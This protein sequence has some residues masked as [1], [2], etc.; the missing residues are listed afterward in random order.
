MH[1]DNRRP[2]IRVHTAGRD[3]VLTLDPQ[4]AHDLAQTI[5]QAPSPRDEWLDEVARTLRALSER[6]QSTQLTNGRRPLRTAGYP[7][8]QGTVITDRATGSSATA[9]QS[10]STGRSATPPP[11]PL[12][13]P[14]RRRTGPR[15]PVRRPAAAPAP[16]KPGS[17]LAAA[18]AV[19]A[20]AVAVGD[21]APPAVDAGG[22]KSS[23]REQRAQ[24]LQEILAAAA[25]TAQSESDQD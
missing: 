5:G 17:G 12:G 21:Q 6:L 19:F 25:R 15:T 16:A 3:V 9:T 10:V 4:Q 11:F 1:E 22:R 20:D 13:P 24:D 18:V 8:A 2:L 14:R 23:T 7:M